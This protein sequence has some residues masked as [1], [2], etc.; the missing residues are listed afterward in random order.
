[1]RLAREARKAEFVHLRKC[2]KVR[3]E[4]V[5]LPKQYSDQALLV[6]NQVKAGGRIAYAGASLIYTSSGEMNYGA[7]CL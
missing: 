3:S 1:M 5:W 2:G 4:R 6:N 7:D